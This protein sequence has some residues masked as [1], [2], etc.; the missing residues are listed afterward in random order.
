MLPT[1]SMEIMREEGEMRPFFLEGGR[2]VLTCDSQS[3]L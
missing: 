3:A 1:L 2:V